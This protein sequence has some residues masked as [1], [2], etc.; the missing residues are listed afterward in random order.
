MIELY[1]EDA[2]IF[3][4]VSRDTRVNGIFSFRDT[5]TELRKV[6]L[7]G[8]RGFPGS[9]LDI[10]IAPGK[11][12]QVSGE[13]KLITTW[14]VTSDIPEQEEENRYKA[15]ALKERKELMKL[16]VVE[17]DLLRAI[18]L[19]HLAC[20][21]FCPEIASSVRKSYP[22]KRTGIYAKCPLIEGLDK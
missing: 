11:Y 19:D 20:H 21:R 18:F 3:K 10:W 13:D 12:I 2:G 7:A 5:V 22:G 15:C 6:E 8:D 14:N 16:E 9:R 17:Y 1:E 4:C